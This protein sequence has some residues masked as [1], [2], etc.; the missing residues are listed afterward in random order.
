MEMETIKKT[1]KMSKEGLKIIDL[2]VENF[3][4]ITKKVV[5]LD[6]RS[7]IILGGNGAGKSSLI[8]SIL[9]PLDSQYLPAQPIK[10]GEDRARIKLKIGGEL[11]SEHKEYIIDMYF[12]EAN[13]T[14]RL[15]VTNHL[16][17]TVKAGRTL[18]KSILG[19]IGFDIFA[20]LRSTPAKQVAILKE[21][22]GVDFNALDI[23]RAEAYSKRTY[24]NTRIKEEEAL[25]NNSGFTQEQIDLYSKPVD[26]AEL[27]SEMANI[28]ESIENW[29]RVSGGI[30][31]RERTIA[32]FN[33]HICDAEVKIAN[34]EAEILRLQEDIQLKRTQISTNEEDVAKGNAWLLNNPKP[35]ASEIQAKLNSAEAHNEKHQKVNAYAAKA[36]AIVKLKAESEALTTSIEEVDKKKQEMIANSNLPVPGLTFTDTGAYLD[37]LEL[38]DLQI[39]KSRLMNVGLRIAS[40]MHPNLRVGIIWDASLFDAEQLRE[41]FRFG[42]ENNMQILAEKVDDEGGAL[43]I[44]FS[45]QYFEVKE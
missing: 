3:K 27:K 21:L 25:L 40:A 8:Q 4:N 23:Q 7:L 9:S 33:Q 13:Q 14:G 31:E 28:S 26:T 12:T 44:K 22:A 20:F 32:S 19:T 37:G 5:H 16:G 41:I 18:I 11:F 1:K 38:S 34:M 17:E 2:E 30:K 10:E 42:E 15:V 24:T 39:N 45:E 36:T 35:S 43:D 6:G 29:M